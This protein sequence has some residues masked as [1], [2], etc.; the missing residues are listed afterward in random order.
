MI[1]ATLYQ[2]ARVG[3]VFSKEHKTIERPDCSITE[4]Y[5][6]LIND[7]WQ[8]TGKLYEKNEPKKNKSKGKIETEIET[9][10]E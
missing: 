8:T 3:G 6:N 2:L 9:N 4:D 7:N 1:Q 10:I 5:Y